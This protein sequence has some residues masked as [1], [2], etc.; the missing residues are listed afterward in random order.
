M[1]SRTQLVI[2]NI[3]LSPP[4][5]ACI[6]SSLH[7]TRWQTCYVWPRLS[8]APLPQPSLMACGGWCLTVT[9]QD[10][11]FCNLLFLLET[12]EEE[13]TEAETK[14][15][16]KQEETERGRKSQRVTPDSCSGRGLHGRY[17]DRVV[18]RVTGR[19]RS[20]TWSAYLLLVQTQARS[21]KRAEVHTILMQR[22]FT[23]IPGVEN[24]CCTAQMYFHYRSTDPQSRLHLPR[25]CHGLLNLFLLMK[26][27][28]SAQ[29]TNQYTS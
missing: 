3:P 25:L 17:P 15:T 1:P 28:Q 2:T 11:V 20:E 22:E 8:D 13:Q 5:T 26:Q 16:R 27:S 19:Y 6:Q 14:Q 9:P 7:S 12:E 29:Y 24:I 18:G 10:N 23:H 4:P 21:R